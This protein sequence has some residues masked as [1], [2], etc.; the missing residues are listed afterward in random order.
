MIPRISVVR[1]ETALADSYMFAWRIAE[2]YDLPLKHL[3]I[4]FASKL[5]GMCP[6]LL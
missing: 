5:P 4:H 2:L 3:M 6:D 1:L